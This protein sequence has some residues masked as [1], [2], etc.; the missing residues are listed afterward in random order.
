LAGEAT[1]FHETTLVINFY[2]SLSCGFP[3]FFGADL[4]RRGSAREAG[5]P[6]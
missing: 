2:R 1:P 4:A 6:L 5:E 3:A